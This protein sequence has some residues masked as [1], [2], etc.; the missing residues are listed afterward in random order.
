MVA[1]HEEPDL[2]QADREERRMKD[3]LIS[4]EAAIDAADDLV[5]PQESEEI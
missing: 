1:G 3:D 5:V 4:R 2:L